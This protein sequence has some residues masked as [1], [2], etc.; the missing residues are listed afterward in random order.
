MF[1]SFGGLEPL[2]GDPQQFH[3]EDQCRTARNAWLGELAVTHFGGDVELPF[4][5][6]VH[7]LHGDDP[8]LDQVAKPASQR[9][10]A[11]AAVELFPVDGLPCVVGG[12]DAADRRFR[13]RRV[14]FVHHFVVDTLGQRLDARFLRLLLKPLLV[15]LYVLLFR[16]FFC[17]LIFDTILVKNPQSLAIKGGYCR[18]FVLY[19]WFVGIIQS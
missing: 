11:S 19:N 7:L 10:A 13:A 17:V 8:T 5:A 2:S 4:I 6:Y 9:Y 1:I 14:P 18:I 3:L 15:R 12:D 16:H